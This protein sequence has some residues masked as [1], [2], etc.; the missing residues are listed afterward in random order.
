[1]DLPITAVKIVVGIH[2]RVACEKPYL[3]GAIGYISQP[4]KVN[5]GA[6]ES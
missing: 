4:T 2:T 1:V 3:W 6:K 5:Q